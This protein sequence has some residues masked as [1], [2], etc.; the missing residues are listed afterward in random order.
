MEVVSELKLYESCLP[1]N[2][3]AE[4]QWIQRTLQLPLYHPIVEEPPVLE[5]QHVEVPPML[6]KSDD[7]I[8]LL[9]FMRE[10][11]M[12]SSV[13]VLNESVL[14]DIARDTIYDRHHND[15]LTNP[16]HAN[17]L[18][19]TRRENPQGMIHTGLLDYMPPQA[20][21]GIHGASNI[22]TNMISLRR[23][24][25]S[26]KAETAKIF[27]E[28]FTASCRRWNQLILD[29]TVVHPKTGEVIRRPPCSRG[30]PM[31]GFVGC[32]VYQISNW[33]QGELGVLL[34]LAEVKRFT[35]HGE[36]PLNCETR[37]CLLCESAWYVSQ[38][39]LCNPSGV[40]YS[41]SPSCPTMLYQDIFGVNNG[42]DPFWSVGPG[43]NGAFPPAPFVGLHINELQIS[44]ENGYMFVDE[45]NLWFGYRRP[46]F[47]S[48]ATC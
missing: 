27:I 16:F 7:V 9:L 42:F 4:L 32:M 48:G 8:T 41:T 35:E 21:S 18:E 45:H 26:K 30:E 22:I 39:G 11:V 3:I 46:D 20:N 37:R 28:T 23:K 34:S 36:L 43:R 15:M 17:M 14:A 38:T 47:R 25:G 6:S 44:S 19:E 24:P 1:M 10:T 29:H 31:D 5:P 12:G 33:T 13:A 40:G 2:I